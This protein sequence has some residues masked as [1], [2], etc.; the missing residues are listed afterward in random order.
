MCATLAS[1]MLCDSMLGIQFNMSICMLLKVYLELYLRVFCWSLDTMQFGIMYDN[2]WQ[3]TRSSVRTCMPWKW[4]TYDRRPR[5]YVWC[6]YIHRQLSGFVTIHTIAKQTDRHMNTHT[7]PARAALEHSSMRIRKTPS[8]YSGKCV[9]VRFV[10][11][12]ATSLM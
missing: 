4:Q 3:I 10:S 2:V 8:T 11:L 1:C 5:V 6:S 9:S 12:F 7:W